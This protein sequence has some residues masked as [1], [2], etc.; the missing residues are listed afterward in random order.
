MSSL[1][2]EQIVFDSDNGQIG[3]QVDIKQLLSP[4]SGFDI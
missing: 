3:Y 1:V 2:E 4:D